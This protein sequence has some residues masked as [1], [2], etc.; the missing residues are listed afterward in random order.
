MPLRVNIDTPDGKAWTEYFPFE[1]GSTPALYVIRADG[2]QMYGRSGSPA[3][4]PQ[5]LNEQLKNA[6]EIPTKKQLALLARASDEASRLYL[7]DELDA[8]VEKVKPFAEA[9]SYALPCVQLKRLAEQF[10]ERG[11]EAIATAGE[12]MRREQPTLKDAL[13]LARTM[14]TFEDLPGIQQVRNDTLSRIVNTEDKRRLLAQAEMIDEAMRLEEDS[15]DA[16]AAKLYRDLLEQYPQGEAARLARDRLVSLVDE[17][18][19]LRAP[20][21]SAPSEPDLP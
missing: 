17:G 10:A 19:S 8:A 2:E 1:G 6:G 9:N 7:D 12:S 3:N 20:I 5:F 18:D 13:L 21:N 4:L 16:R 14:R 11:E 15:A